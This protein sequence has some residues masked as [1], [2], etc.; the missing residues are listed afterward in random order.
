MLHSDAVLG[1]CKIED[2]WSKTCST[3]MEAALA[4]AVDVSVQED[5]QEFDFGSD[6]AFQGELHGLEGR[7]IEGQGS[8]HYG[9]Q[10]ALL[11]FSQPVTAPK[12]CM[13]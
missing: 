3:T 6:Y 10:W 11:K 5:V 2:I 12:V 1:L 8:V 7:P 4:E 13:T 9:P